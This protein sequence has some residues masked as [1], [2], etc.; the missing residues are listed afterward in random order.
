[1]GPRAFTRGDLFAPP[2][3]GPVIDASMGPRAFTRGDRAEEGG[4][5]NTHVSF[6]GATRIHAWRPP[7]GVRFRIGRHGFNGATRIHAWR[8]AVDRR[9]SSRRE[10]FNGATRIHAW[11]LAKHVRGGSRIVASMGPRAFTRGDFIEVKLD[12]L[13]DLASMGPRAFTRGDPQASVSQ[14]FR[15]RLQ[16]GHAHS[17]VETGG[18]PRRG[19]SSTGFNGATR[20]HAWRPTRA[21]G[22]PRARRASMGPRAFTRGDRSGCRPSGGRPWA[23]MGPRAFTRGDVNTP[24]PVEAHSTA[25]MGPR[26][27]TRGDV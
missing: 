7:V 25:S 9:D 27:F 11:R 2:E 23:S 4:S 6:N 12:N 19:T 21:R 18:R 10:R 3:L 14:L 5:N 22:G 13:A 8:Q 26:A 17:R 20:I 16:W 24:P 15:A 1:M